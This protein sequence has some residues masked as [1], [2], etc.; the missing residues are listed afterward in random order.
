MYSD[1]PWWT[2]ALIYILSAQM[3]IMS[4][5]IYL[6]RYLTHRSIKEMHPAL[7]HFFR[8][9][10][11]ITTGMKD[12]EWVPIHRLHHIHVETEKDPHSPHVYGFAKVFWGG[13][14]LYHRAAKD[15]ESLAPYLDGL[16]N[17]WIERNLY[18][19][20][21]YVG[22]IFFLFLQVV[23]FGWIGVAMW[24]AHI[25]VIA[26][27]GQGFI[28]GIGHYWGYRNYDT[29]DESRNITR[30]GIF[31]GGEEL[32][33]NH[34]DNLRSANFARSREIDIGFLLIRAFQKVGLIGKVLTH[35]KA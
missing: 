23:L 2:Y 20:W 17:D 5:S 1:W 6:H 11:F 29:P 33:N 25:P 7:S 13:A 19:R 32:H 14:F 12:S 18:A 34:H 15:K 8:F 4:V 10:K 3:T 28:N 16:P 21:S 24:L 31:A 35:N 27:F 9:W 22:I 30:F 26:V